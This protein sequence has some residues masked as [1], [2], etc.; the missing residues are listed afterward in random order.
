MQFWGKVRLHH[1]IQRSIQLTSTVFRLSKPLHS[2]ANELEL[3]KDANLKSDDWFEIYDPRNPLNKR[4][5]EGNKLHEKIKK[6]KPT[7]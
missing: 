7:D 1:A 2:V 4:R 5:R 6:L 3:A